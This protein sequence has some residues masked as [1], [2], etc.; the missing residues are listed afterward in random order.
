MCVTFVQ[1]Q[2]IT[3]GFSVFFLPENVTEITSDQL[4]NSVTQFCIVTK[5]DHECYFFI[6]CF[7]SPLCLFL[8]WCKF[9]VTGDGNAF[10][11][12]AFVLC[13]WGCD[14]RA[15]RGG[16]WCL[17]VEAS[18]FY[19]HPISETRMHLWSVKFA[20]G[21]VVVHWCSPNP[22][23]LL[24][25]ASVAQQFELFAVWRPGSIL[26]PL[27]SWKLVQCCEHACVWVAVRLWSA[28]I[29]QGSNFL[30]SFVF[31]TRSRVNVCNAT[32][33]SLL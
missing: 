28:K 24:G 9:S 17:C 8:P 1:P 15:N 16:R 13:L 21:I 5:H 32:G 22:C 33:T 20:A 25:T 10:S 12:F 30:R 18:S 3:L 6:C 29:R 11:L 27:A 2:S 19:G 4:I 31:A 14:G 26:T 23:I 7:L